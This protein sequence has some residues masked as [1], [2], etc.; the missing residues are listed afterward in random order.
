MPSLRHAIDD[1]HVFMP[2]EAELHEPLAVEI[3]R[4]LLQNG[5]AAGVVL[6]E[7]VVGAEDGSNAALNSNT[8]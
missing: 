8:G 4:H 5:D 6:D 3:A 7:V 1:P 2:K